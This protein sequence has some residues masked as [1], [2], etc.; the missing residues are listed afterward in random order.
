MA[1]TTTLK[2]IA[3]DAYLNLLV[4]SVYIKLLGLLRGAEPG[5]CARIS[6]LPAE[7]MFKLCPL[8]RKA[9]LQAD[10]LSLLGEEEIQQYE[11]QAKSTK[12]IELRNAEE[13]PLLV[14]MP[15]TVRVS[16]NDSIDISTFREIPLDNILAEMKKLILQQL[17][18]ALANQAQQLLQIVRG[19]AYR[20]LTPESEIRYYLSLAANQHNPVAVG[21]A[22]CQ[23]GLLPDF[24]VVRN[25]G[26]TAA[27]ID[28]NLSTIETI[29]D[30]RES[31]L[32][33][34]HNLQLQPGT[35]QKDFYELLRYSPTL[36]NSV[37]WTRR[38]ATESGWNHLSFDNLP[39]RESGDKSTIEIYLSELGLPTEDGQALLDLTKTPTLTIY[40]QTDPPQVQCER[41][42]HFRVEFVST[43]GAI[44]E[45]PGIIKKA[46][47]RSKK[48]S[49]KLSKLDKLNL[50]EGL[51]FI[52]VRAY[53]ESNQL[54]SDEKPRDEFEPEAQKI[55]ESQ[56]F[57]V[58]FTGDTLSEDSR[59]PRNQIVPGFAFAHYQT[60]LNQLKGNSTTPSEEELESKKFKQFQKFQW[61]NAGKKGGGEAQAIFTIQYNE[62]NIYSVVVSRILRQVEAATLQEPDKL[63]LWR[64]DFSTNRSGSNVELVRRENSGN[65]SENIPPRFKKARCQLFERIAAG[66]NMY[67]VP[68]PSTTEPYLT[69]LIDLTAYSSEIQEYVA[70]YNEWLVDVRLT[71]LDNQDE[72][73]GLLKENPLFLELDTLEVQFAFGL[74]DVQKVLLLAPTHPLRL[75]WH[76]QYTRL[77]KNW[78]EQASQHNKQTSRQMLEQNPGVQQLT[79]GNLLPTN[80]PPM[81][82]YRGSGTTRLFVDSGSLGHFWQL[83]LDPD[84]KD[85]RSVRSRL[86]QLLGLARSTVSTTAITNSDGVSR[87]ELVRKLLR[88]LY[89]HPYVDTLKINLFNPGDARLLVECLLDLQKQYRDLKYQVRLFAERTEGTEIG[90]AI[91]D[92]LNPQRQVSD[93]QDE[94]VTTSRNHLFPKLKFSRNTINQYLKNP[95]VFDAHI[96]LL[97]NYFPIEVDLAT[98]P[99]D[100]RSSFAYGLVQ[101]SKQTFISENNDYYKWQQ[102]LQPN[103]CIELDAHAYSALLAQLLD[104][105]QNLQG[106]YIEGR[107]RAEGT[108]PVVKLDL[109]VADRRL[110]YLVHEY[111]D[112]VLTIDRNLGLEYFDDPVL[113]GNLHPPL[114]LLDYVPE[115]SRTNGER[116]LLTTRSSGEVTRLLAPNLNHFGIVGAGI[117]DIALKA[118]RTLSGRLVLKLL[119]SYNKREEVVSLVLAQ[120]FLKQFGLL[121]N[122]FVIPLDAHTELFTTQRDDQLEKELSLKRTDL[123][124]VEVDT[125]A[126]NLH[127]RLVEVKARKSVGGAGSLYELMGQMSKQLENSRDVL[128]RHFDAEFIEPDRLDRQFKTKEFTDLL[129]F[130]LERGFRYKLLNQEY[131]A[132][133]RSFLQQLDN[134]YKLNFELTGLIFDFST[135]D[136]T[137]IDDSG[138]VVHVIG[139]DYIERMIANE[140]E[141]VSSTEQVESVAIPMQLAPAFSEVTSFFE[142]QTL[143]HLPQ[144]L[145]V[146]RKRLESLLNEPSSNNDTYLSKTT[147]LDQAEKNSQEQPLT[148]PLLVETVPVT[149]TASDYTVLATVN[150][151]NIPYSPLTQNPHV[152]NFDAGQLTEVIVT[153]QPAFEVFLGDNYPSPQYGILGKS[154]NRTVALDLNG[155]NT[156]SVFGVQGGGKSYTVGTIAEMALQPVPAINQLPSPLATVIFHYNE[157]QDYAPEFVSMVEAN[158]KGLEIER[159]AEEYG[160][161]PTALQDVLLL[162]TPDKLSERKREFPSVVVEPIYFHSSEL[163]IKDWKFLMGALSNQSMYLT[164]M[165]MIMRKYRSELTL[166]NLRRGIEDSGLSQSQKD[167]ALMRLSFASQFINDNY[168]LSEKLKPGRLIIVDVRDE[169]IEQDEALGLFVVMLNIFA[170]VS[171]ANGNSFNKLIIFDEAHKYMSNPELTGNIV[172]VV[173]QMRHQGVSV[174]IASQDPLSLPNAIIELS[175]VMILHR[176]NAP[177]WIR[178]IQKS[179]TALGEL[180]PAQLGALATGEAYVWANKAT[181]PSFTNRAVKIRCRPRVT[182]HGGNTKTAVR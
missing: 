58:T 5:H 52:R 67:D 80:L 175:S 18:M 160:A 116:L 9:G 131:F 11:W 61:E 55:N 38:I 123:L 99:K 63:G 170:N 166:N 158:S 161:K 84:T 121:C 13:R 144:L 40:W 113:T 53:N 17:P 70:S 69:S 119:S 173:R 127:L 35:V 179:Q 66:S 14:F 176:F 126:R 68:P 157:S 89:Q 87:E 57:L 74:N 105:I 79:S 62:R 90:Q 93:E 45:Y 10:I 15:P 162:T 16:T 22:I 107:F 78:F 148:A 102:T 174:V 143:N 26:Q 4:E 75:L 140:L 114:Y 153:G 142:P 41:L 44:I 181:E 27:R 182:L 81:L 7:A 112:W 51:Y 23:L 59:S 64:L 60:L 96:S 25:P 104:N 147:E 124:L 171:E 149:P 31:L 137:Q 135:S 117:E 139:Q 21:G 47:G 154:G 151:E 94:F 97:F 103:S 138:M 167:L 172:E 177:N 136:I 48:S 83:Y 132:Q 106:A 76:L 86:E 133:A 178:H 110:I 169:L 42:D 30:S 146:R 88:Y 168:H 145:E 36:T 134:G 155:C 109:G 24:E 180:V 65:F 39:W 95:E 3:S 1:A 120:I 91:E 118:L 164:Q 125:K 152:T 71:L 73:T 43:M 49:K 2:S 82:T 50:E 34:L 12:I 163:G 20:Y 141:V 56:E 8:L 46:K 100:N 122:R 85:S 130:Y 150:E 101:E 72:A 6:T 159:L 19:Q 77:L 129:S 128:R 165:T 111:S 54:I 115:Y 92:L 108:V 98:N 37:T 28:L 156:I 29:I 33:R 32:V